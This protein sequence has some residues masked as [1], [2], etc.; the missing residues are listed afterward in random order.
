MRRF[1][2]FWWKCAQMAFWGNTA[3]AN[4]WQWLI[5]YPVTAILLWLVGAYYAE[6][7]GRI[8]LTLT[9]GALGVLAAALAAF[10][11][12]WAARFIVRLLNASVLLFHAEKERADA[13]TGP[14]AAQTQSYSRVH[15]TAYQQ[16]QTLEAHVFTK[17]RLN[18]I[19]EGSGEFRNSA[20]IPGRTGTAR[21]TANVLLD[22]QG[23]EIF[24]NV[25]KNTDVLRRAEGSH[26]SVD[27]PINSPRDELAIYVYQGGPGVAH[28]DPNHANTYAS[29][30][31]G[32]A[33]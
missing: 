7:S 27:V 23:R 3:F 25:F 29:F 22:E 10:I 2:C 33:P 14:T 19:L 13:A 12:T 32:N 5:G 9:T 30:Q 26:I 24:I 1:F 20:W 31:I 11:I 17:L 21:I 16:P 4:D 6:L 18:G 15:A 28:I 8:E